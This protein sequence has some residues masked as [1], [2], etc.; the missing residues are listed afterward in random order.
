MY[1]ML[2]VCAALSM[3]GCSSMEQPAPK[4]RIVCVTA[5]HG[6][7]VEVPDTEAYVHK[8]GGLNCRAVYP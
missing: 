7:P 8:D 6:I 5:G 1:R 3:A 4:W 2:Y